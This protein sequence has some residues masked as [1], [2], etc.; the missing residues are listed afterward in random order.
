VSTNERELEKLEIQ[1]IM[2]TEGG[3][4]FMF[5]ILTQAGTYDTTFDSD[6]YIHA[7][8][9]GRRENGL[10]LDNELREA[11]HPNYLRMLKENTDDE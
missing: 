5:R 3:R 6:P 10:W 2:S 7:R 9:S 1:R 11:T 8:N 4:A